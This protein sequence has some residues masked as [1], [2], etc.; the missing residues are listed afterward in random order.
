MNTRSLRF[1]G[2]GERQKRPRAA[3]FKHT[4]ASQRRTPQPGKLSELTR[5]RNNYCKFCY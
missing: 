2:I 3:I 5:P 1:A 4:L